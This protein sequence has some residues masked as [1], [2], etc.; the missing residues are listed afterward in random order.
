MLDFWYSARCPRQ[1]KLV[2]C[3][4]TFA[5]LYYCSTLNKL[6]AHFSIIALLIGMLTHVLYQLRSGQQAQH[7]A[8]Q[9]LWI[10]LRFLPLLALVLFIALIPRLQQPILIIQ[11]F[12]FAAFGLFLMSIFSQRARRFG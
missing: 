10:V 1:L 11:V 8:P 6:E 4:L 12:G 2:I 3:V 5:L 9:V 7:A